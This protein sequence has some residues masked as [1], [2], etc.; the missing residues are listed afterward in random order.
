MAD[1]K[2][3]REKQAR[4]AEKRQRE[5]EL[6]EARDRADESEPPG[7]AEAEDDHVSDETPPE[8]HRRGCG[9]QAAFVVL[10]RYLEETGKGAVEATAVLC[11]EHTAEESP[12]NLDGAYHDYVFHVQPLEGAVET[13]TA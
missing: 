12:V 6:A 3:G 2:K 5:R 9:E 11:R 13:E 4:N 8:C 7:D 1:T 10:E